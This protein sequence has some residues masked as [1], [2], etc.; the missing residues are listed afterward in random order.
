MADRYVT[1]GPEV[2]AGILDQIDL[3]ALH[4]ALDAV[5]DADAETDF[6]SADDHNVLRDLRTQLHR[7]G[8][9]S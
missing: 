9:G 2:L 8:F 5:I 7:A 1:A 4:A 3:E 6:L